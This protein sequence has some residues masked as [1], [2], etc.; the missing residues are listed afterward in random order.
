MASGPLLLEKRLPT[1]AGRLFAAFLRADFTDVLKLAVDYWR[2]RSALTNSDGSWLSSETGGKVPHDEILSSE[3]VRC[4]GLIAQSLRLD[5]QR[6]LSQSTR[7]LDGL[8]KLAARTSEPYIWLTM[9]LTPS[10]VA[11]CY[12]SSS[13]WRWTELL[14]DQIGTEGKAVI[15]A[16]GVAFSV[17]P[18]TR[19]ALALSTRRNPSPCELGKSFAMCTPTGSGKTYNRRVGY[20]QDLVRSNAGGY[21][22]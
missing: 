6:C 2:D 9:A 19:A 18:R 4:L 20:P 11:E 13:L 21:E 16:Y 3:V 15:A 12:A 10:H 7:K 8:S 5:D 1:N 17:P 14:H 22:R